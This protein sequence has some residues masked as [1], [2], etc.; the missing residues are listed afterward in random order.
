MVSRLSVLLVQRE[1][2]KSVLSANKRIIVKSI[3]GRLQWAMQPRLVRL[4]SKARTPDPDRCRNR[5][6]AEHVECPTVIR[7]AA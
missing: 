2:A 3:T 7:W 4:D 5:R 1:K 6:R